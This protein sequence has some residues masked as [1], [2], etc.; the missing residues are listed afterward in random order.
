MRRERAKHVAA[1]AAA[2]ITAVHAGARCT[3]VE[4]ERPKPIVNERAPVDVALG[5]AE[6]PSTAPTPTAPARAPLKSMS[7]ESRA[8]AQRDTDELHA[9]NGDPFSWEDSFAPRERHRSDEDD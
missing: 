3:P 6:P 7:Q 2:T 9:V 8:R 1:N 5:R 4:L